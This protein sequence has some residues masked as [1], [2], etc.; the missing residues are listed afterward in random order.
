M[1]NPS[2]P[3]EGTGVK[4][5]NPSSRISPMMPSLGE[6]SVHEDTSTELHKSGRNVHQHRRRSSLGQTLDNLLELRGELWSGND[7]ARFFAVFTVL[8]IFFSFLL[9]QQQTVETRYLLNFFLGA[10]NLCF[11]QFAFKSVYG[12]WFSENKVFLYGSVSFV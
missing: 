7:S 4:P 11:I 10:L 8:A 12:S 3:S 6:G 5:K 2:A 9:S 1:M